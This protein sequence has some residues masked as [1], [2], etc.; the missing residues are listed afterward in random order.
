MSEMKHTPGPW[1]VGDG[2]VSGSEHI[3]YCDDATGSAVATV[4]FEPLDITGRS[5]TE[6]RANAHLISAAPDMYEALKAAVDCGMVPVTSVSEGGA[7]RFSRQ[8]DVADM[9]R[10][11]LQKAT[12]PEIQS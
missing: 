4:L 1:E 8:V 12:P 5:K 3:I 9:I 11:A 2:V 6:R 7:A 10:A